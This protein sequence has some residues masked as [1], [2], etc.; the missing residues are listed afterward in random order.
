MRQDIEHREEREI[1][2]NV[3][4]PTADLVDQIERLGGRPASTGHP[5]LDAVWPDEWRYRLAPEFGPDRLKLGRATPGPAAEEALQ[6]YPGA[7]CFGRDEYDDLLLLLLPDG[8]SIALN[9]FLE[10]AT[11]AEAPAELLAKLELDVASSSVAAPWHAE[12]FYRTFSGSVVFAIAVHDECRAVV[13]SVPSGTNQSGLP[14]SS[15][16]ELDPDG[17]VGVFQSLGLPTEQE[18]FLCS[19]AMSLKEELEFALPPAASAPPNAPPA[20]PGETLSP[21][22]LQHVYRL[23]GTLPPPPAQPAPTDWNGFP[24]PEPLR[25]FLFDTKWTGGRMYEGDGY[26]RVWSYQPAVMDLGSSSYPFNRAHPDAVVFGIADGGNYFLLTFASAP[27]PTDPPVYRLDHDEYD[28]PASGPVPLSEFL[29]SLGS[30]LR[31]EQRQRSPELDRPPQF[32]QAPELNRL[33]RTTNGSLVS[34]RSVDATGAD[35]IVLTGGHTL[36]RDCIPGQRPGEVYRVNGYGLY[37][38]PYI[39]DLRAQLSLVELLPIPLA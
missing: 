32:R 8:S 24:L 18:N 30:D 38:G 33:F 2:S 29:A 7:V 5:L 39:W 21:V 16:Y 22:I 11:P 17:A 3:T 35:V 37:E 26:L 25:R 36:E 1:E 13:L 28:A 10:K 9:T 12:R 4:Q 31:S 14:V 19:N 27:D 20:Y 15:V 6:P 23:G 34:A